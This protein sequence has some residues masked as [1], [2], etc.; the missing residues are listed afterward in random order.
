MEC[1]LEEKVRQSCLASL[2]SLSD[3][4]GAVSPSPLLR[5]V[6]VARLSFSCA[7]AGH[8]D[9]SRIGFDPHAA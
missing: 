3:M 4:Y 8:S 7:F 1:D 9:Y 2:T 5:L 6:I